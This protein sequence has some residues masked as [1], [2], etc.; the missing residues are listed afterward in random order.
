M[1]VKGLGDED[2]DD[3]SN[4]NSN[5]NNY[6]LCHYSELISILNILHYFGIFI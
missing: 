2:T 3:S 5:S 6:F 4:Y 1:Q